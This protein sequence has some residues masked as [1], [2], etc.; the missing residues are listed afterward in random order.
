MP[1]ESCH[2]YALSKPARTD[3]AELLHRHGLAL[4]GFAP[5]DLQRQHDVGQDGAPGEQRRSLEDVAIGASQPRLV[6]TH[7]ID[8]DRSRRDR[9]QIGNDAQK[10]RLAA[11]RRTD[12]GNELARRDGQVD[13]AQGVHRR[14]YR[15]IDDA[16]AARG[17]GELA[18]RAVRQTRDAAFDRERSSRRFGTRETWPNGQLIVGPGKPVA[19]QAILR[20]N[21]VFTWPWRLRKIAMAPD[22]MSAFARSLEGSAAWQRP[23]SLSPDGGPDIRANRRDAARIRRGPSPM[24]RHAF[25]APR[26]R[27]RPSRCLY[28]HDAPCVEACPTGIDVPSLHPPHRRRQTCAVR[29]A[30]SRGQSARRHLCPRLSTEELCEQVC[31]RVAQQGKP[32]EIGRLQRYAVD[33]GWIVR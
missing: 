2:G 6:R 27:S 15:Q 19:C 16:D 20:A 31:V 21:P 14:V 4:G 33:A 26:P 8:L 17:D 12:E 24:P 28:C 18:R 9:L 23:P 29:R 25:P 5:L 13:L 22:Q 30:P 3:A 11:A 1:P 32:V 10:G 7:A